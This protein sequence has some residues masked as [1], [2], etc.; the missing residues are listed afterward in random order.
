[1]TT[2][3]NDD[4]AKKYIDDAMKFMRVSDEQGTIKVLTE[5]IEKVPDYA[6][7]YTFR[8]ACFADHEKYE[9]ALKDFDKAISLTQDNH[10]LSM[11]YMSKAFMKCMSKKFDD[12]DD[13]F[14]KAIE[15]NPKNAIALQL[16]GENLIRR[17]MG[18]QALT[19]LEK[20]KE[21]FEKE[22]CTDMLYE[23]DELIERAK[24]QKN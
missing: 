24:Q 19:Y 18:S 10:S 16:Y 21:L 14:K 12:F 7:L 3:P 15:T 13:D 11:I 1:M 6:S 5:G 9:E 22:G 4:L 20:A 8:A 23:T 2:P 17:N